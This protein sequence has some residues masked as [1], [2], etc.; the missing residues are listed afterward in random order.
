MF[1]L[2]KRHWLGDKDILMVEPAGDYASLRNKKVTI[3]RTEL[4]QAKEFY[5][6]RVEGQSLEM[7]LVVDPGSSSAIDLKLFLSEDGE[8]F[9]LVKLI[10][11]GEPYN[12]LG[13]ERWTVMID[14][15]Y[16]SLRPEVIY[17]ATI[18]RA[19]FLRF[20]NEPLHVKLFLDNS[21]VE[22]FVN[23]Q[24]TLI[25]RVYPLKKDS[26]KVSIRPTGNGVVLESLTAWQMGSIWE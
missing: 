2:P 1:S 19:E 20:D 16:S 15:T 6:E 14:P 4:S 9:T 18:P 22:V 26:R 5:P 17:K 12:T 13:G 8:E 24:A 23:D 3:G 7:E 25:E 10:R 11:G 21:V